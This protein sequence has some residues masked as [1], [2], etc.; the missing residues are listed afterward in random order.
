MN[1]A[2]LEHIL[3]AAAAVSNE[4]ERDN[5]RHGRPAMHRVLSV[6]I[7]FTFGAATGSLL[8]VSG[9][10][11]KPARRHINLPDRRPNAPYS[12][13]VL[14]GDT[15][16]LAGR[17][18]LDPKTGKVPTDL[19][20]E[21]RIMLDSMKTQLAEA[22]MTM[23]DL[24]S[25]QV[26]CPDLTLYDRFNQIYRTYFKGEMPARA[27]IGSGPLLGGSRFEVQGIAVRR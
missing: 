1:R 11:Q 22:G 10:A 23:D 25:V 4:R 6:L 14:A 20:Q 15:L 26:F 18:G 12:Q 16:Y 2:A 9:S 17:T 19:E 13:A 21:V 5:P 3:R 7:V 24:V 27:F 8:T